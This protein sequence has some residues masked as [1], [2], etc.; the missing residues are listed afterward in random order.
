MKVFTAW[1]LLVLAFPAFAQS[2]EVNDSQEANP[3]IQAAPG[4]GKDKAKQY[5]QARK[6][7]G[8]AAAAGEP[9]AAPHFLALHFGGFFQDQS[10][11]WGDNDKVGNS[12]RFNGGVTY[13][14]GEWVSSMDLSLRAEYT[15]YWFSEENYARKLSFSPVITFPDA[16]SRFP[17]YF[18]GGVGLGIFTHQIKDE[19]PVSFDWQVFGGVRFLDVFEH[20]GFMVE[21]GMK[22]HVLLFSDGQ[23]NGVFIN[24]GTVFAF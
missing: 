5:F 3:P 16:N 15:T 2:V 12:G 11:K 22:N 18:G 6:K 10:Y 4:A 1:L 19:S 8:A 13:R 24:V 20:I 7:D 17:L 23:F 14:M 21:A 9:G